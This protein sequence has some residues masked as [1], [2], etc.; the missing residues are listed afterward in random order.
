MSIGEIAKIHCSPDYA[1]KYGLLAKGTR[2]YWQIDHRDR[3]KTLS[4]LLLLLFFLC[5]RR[6]GRVPGLGYHAKLRV[7]VW[8]WSLEL[9]L[10]RE[11]AILYIL[12]LYFMSCTR[13]LYRRSR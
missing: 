9:C 12:L 7:G 8:N 11:L 10:D 13:M 2:C 5:P 3:C 1:C 4:Y 6:P